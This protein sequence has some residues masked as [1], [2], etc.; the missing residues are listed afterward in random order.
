MTRA[1][2]SK[3]KS[4]DFLV[5]SNLHFC[6]QSV[7]L[8]VRFLVFPYQ[9]N[10]RGF[11]LSDHIWKLCIYMFLY[12]KVWAGAILSC[13]ITFLLR[14][15][16][17]SDC[18]WQTVVGCFLFFC[19]FF[20]FPFSMLSTHEL[21]REGC[22]CPCGLR[23]RRGE[24]QAWP[25]QHTLSVAFCRCLKCWYCCYFYLLINACHFS[26]NNLGIKLETLM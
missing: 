3:P 21:P 2:Q 14:L 26:F 13:L 19:L 10:R 23:D 1:C 4:V 5:V 8:M 6:W 22:C 18:K 9:Q 11:C 12:D 17:G 20:F 25:W 15:H 24:Q 16:V 7:N